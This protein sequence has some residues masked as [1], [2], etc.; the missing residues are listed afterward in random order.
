MPTAPTTK[1]SYTVLPFSRH[2]GQLREASHETLGSLRGKRFDSAD[3][4][5]SAAAMAGSRLAMSG[6]SDVFF[7]V[8]WL[9]E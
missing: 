4:A 3:M 6:P 9:P 7:A 2:G 5:C 1:H 8:L